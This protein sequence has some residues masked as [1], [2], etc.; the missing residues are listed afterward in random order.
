MTVIYAEWRPV[1]QVSGAESRIVEWDTELQ[2]LTVVATPPAG[3]AFIRPIVSA[4]GAVG[5][6]ETVAGGTVETARTDGSLWIDGEEIGRPEC[7]FWEHPEFSLDGTQLIHSMQRAGLDAGMQLVITDLDLSFVRTLGDP[8][9]VEPSWTTYY[10]TASQMP[11]LGGLRADVVALDSDTGEP[12]RSPYNDDEIRCYDPFIS[13]DV[14]L[15]VWRRSTGDGVGTSGLRLQNG[16]GDVSWLLPPTPGVIQ[17]TARWTSN[18]T[19]L[20][21]RRNSGETFW[22]LYAANL[23][24]VLTRLT[25]GDQ[26][27]LTNPVMAPGST[28]PDAPP[29]S[30]LVDWGDGSTTAVLL[31]P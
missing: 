10:V 19:L 16:A 8:G 15:T 28:P 23:A 21:S 2:E 14:Q 9:M 3:R 20:T 5:W 6:I 4:S 1:A 13:P 25:D 7:V 27:S 18:S 22:S 31:S 30:G 12:V 26:G 11:V 24:G 29:I 17:G